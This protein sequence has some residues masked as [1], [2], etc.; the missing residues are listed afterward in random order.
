MSNTNA[1]NKLQQQHMQKKQV[2]KEVEKN[3]NEIF[4]SKT[5]NSYW[6]YDDI[7]SIHK[8]MNYRYQLVVEAERKLK[9]QF[10][11]K[12]HEFSY[13]AQEYRD[14]IKE[15]Y[16]ELCKEG[17]HR[18]RHVQQQ[19]DDR[20]KIQAQQQTL[21]RSYKPSRQED[22]DY[23]P[24]NETRGKSSGKKNSS[25]KRKRKDMSGEASKY[26]TSDKRKR[27]KKNDST[28]EDLEESSDGE[29]HHDIGADS[30]DFNYAFWKYVDDFFL[31]VINNDS[32]MQL[33]DHQ[34]MT[35][36]DLKVPDVGKLYRLRWQEEEE[37]EM[38]DN[39]P[40][41]PQ[42]PVT[43][44]KRGR[45]S[46]EALAKQRA[47]NEELQNAALAALRTPASSFFQDKELPSHFIDVNESGDM[48]DSK[49]LSLRLLHSVVEE[50]SVKLSRKKS[51]R[52]HHHRSHTPSTPIYEHS[53]ANRIVDPQRELQVC[54]SD[55]ES[56][57][58][59]STD[60]K[61]LHELRLLGIMNENDFAGKIGEDAHDFFN[62]D[63][64]LSRIEELQK[65]LE[66]Q[67]KV[68]NEHRTV[69]RKAVESKR[70]EEEALDHQWNQ[71]NSFFAEYEAKFGD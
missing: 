37:K 58:L 15:S 16:N 70:V 24:S 41:I 71:D 45:P 27:R 21:E 48:L 5:P 28:Y 60:E 4:K 68:I 8:R 23:S 26:K 36:D 3:Y 9:I 47:K 57:N 32:R 31:P 13:Y 50:R 49:S 51:R 69:I 55:F 43:H 40:I 14:Q 64:V 7:S 62:R 53:D 12:V 22:D 34:S 19:P 46:H 52:F 17:K 39:P 66:K 59:K 30:K 20:Y 54:N 1:Q 10:K 65:E 42:A 61:I 63:D 56:T 11:Q 25:K 67:I 35:D 18:V 38:I 6:T 29:E 2:I 33:L 44:A